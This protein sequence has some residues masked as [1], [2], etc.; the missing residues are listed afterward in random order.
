[1]DSAVAAANVLGPVGTRCTH[2]RA[3]LRLRVPSLLLLLLLLPRL[4]LIF[5]LSPHIGGKPVVCNLFKNNQKA[6][7]DCIMNL[8]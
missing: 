4:L 5:M 2:R 8:F 6:P 3:P 7:E 1:M